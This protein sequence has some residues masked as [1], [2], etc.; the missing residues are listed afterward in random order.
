MYSVIIF[1]RIQKDLNFLNRFSKNNLKYH[2]NFLIVVPYFRVDKETD[3]RTDDIMQLIGD[4]CNILKP[5]NFI[6]ATVK[7]KISAW[8]RDEF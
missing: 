1:V 7:S 6:R 3:G 4:F 2:G 8:L 5:L